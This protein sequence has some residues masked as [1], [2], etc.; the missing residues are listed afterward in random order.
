[1][2]LTL[3]SIYLKTLDPYDVSYEVISIQP[4]L[5]SWYIYI[6]LLAGM[7]NTYEASH[8]ELYA[9]LTTKTNILLSFW[10]RHLSP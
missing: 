6:F 8:A 1:M 9:V 4:Q 3:K 5:R 2:L 10:K 7:E